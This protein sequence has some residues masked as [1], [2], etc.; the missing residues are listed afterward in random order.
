MN[1]MLKRYAV[2]RNAAIL[3][4]VIFGIFVLFFHHR[5]MSFFDS[6]EY[7]T[8]IAGEGI[9]H[10]PGYPLYIMLGKF[11]ML[12]TNDPFSA[13]V[14]I[15]VFSAW[16][17][18]TFLWLSFR[19]SSVWNPGA[20]VATILLL[21]SSYYIKLY[22]LVPEVFLFNLALFTA[23]GWAIARW[24]RQPSARRLFGVF[25]VYG[26]GFAHHHTLALTLPAFGILFFLQLRKIKWSESIGY[27]L[28]GFILGSLP[29][30][31]MFAATNP[32]PN[33]SYYLVNNFQDLL[34]MILRKGYGTFTLTVFQNSASLFDIY[35]LVMGGVAKSFNFIGLLALLPALLFVPKVSKQLVKKD[36]WRREPLLVFSVLTLILFFGFFVSMTNIPL[37]FEKYKHVVLRFVT[38]PV[39]LMLYPIYFGLCAF[40][41]RQENNA[42]SLTWSLGAVIALSNVVGARELNFANFNLLDQH[43]ES[44]FQV[45]LRNSDLATVQGVD[46]SYAKCVFFVRPDALVFSVRYYNE[47]KSARRCFFFTVAS[48]SGQFR[49]RNEERL[50]A[51]AFGTEYGQLLARYQTEPQVLLADLFSRLLTAGFKVYMFYPTDAII[52]QGTNLRFRPVNNV[53]EVVSPNDNLPYSAIIDQHRRYLREV[54]EYLDSLKG[55]NMTSLMLDE[56]VS[57]GYLRNLTEYRKITEPTFNKD[58]E[59]QSLTAQ[60]LDKYAAIFGRRLETIR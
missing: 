27:S 12:I 26:L 13:Q 35:A 18:A 32:Q 34:F 47:F 56:S 60:A 45:A 59:L 25:L 52:F 40:L 31:Y 20:A 1:E 57:S 16:V 22:T 5:G 30:Y 17:A 50:Q 24:Y 49:A 43:I 23:L 29:I 46:P 54:N 8:H 10:A 48:F 37:T 14:M 36:T 41:R 53:V 4:G 55:L 38:I 51:M 7:S 3:A 9:P 19:Q 15:S 6:C 39:L 11:F 58:Q 2:P 28:L 42:R 21:F 33:Y 44:G